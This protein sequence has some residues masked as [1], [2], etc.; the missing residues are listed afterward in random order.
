MAERPNRNREVDRRLGSLSGPVSKDDPRY[1]P[2]RGDLKEDMRVEY[3]IASFDDL[4]R[5][6]AGVF[7][8][9]NSR[10]CSA[11]TRAALSTEDW[12]IPFPPRYMNRPASPGGRGRQVVEYIIVCM[13]NQQ[14]ARELVYLDAKIGI[15]MTT[16]AIL[17]ASFSIRTEGDKNLSEF[18]T[19]LIEKLPNGYTED[20]AAVHDGKRDALADLSRMIDK[21]SGKMT[22]TVLPKED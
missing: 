18:L 1:E 5:R 12:S 7:F 22:V 14:L 20:M 8:D 6:T 4:V 17:L 13:T 2:T 9:Q 3:I 21:F 10:P 19:E 11:G 16:L 15:L